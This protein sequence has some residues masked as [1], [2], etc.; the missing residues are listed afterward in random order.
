MTM[1]ETPTDTKV[2]SLPAQ[3]LATALAATDCTRGTDTT[4][5]AL[6]GW[7][8][9]VTEQDPHTLTV[10][11]C[12]SW[13]GTRATIRLADPV[14][15][16]EILIGGADYPNKPTKLSTLGC[17][18]SVKDPKALLRVSIGRAAV[19]LTAQDGTVNELTLSGH[20]FPTFEK[21]LD[22]TA[23]VIDGQEFPTFNPAYIDCAA[24]SQ[25]A[26]RRAT[27][28][29]L[30]EAHI[31]FQALSR[32]KPAVMVWHS[33]ELKLSVDHLVMPVRVS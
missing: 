21:I 22:G 4:R 19:G 31:T 10:M 13:A 3:A 33:N 18:K 6:S 28:E 24:R 26:V 14:E 1:L 9:R 15:P 27:G 30:L 12:D 5:L 11:S 29:K 25:A 8:V 32:L 7:L 17:L 20:Q 2:I 16:L 23:R